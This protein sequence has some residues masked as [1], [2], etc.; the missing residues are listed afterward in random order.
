MQT[1]SGLVMCL[2]L[3]VHIPFSGNGKIPGEFDE[4]SILNKMILLLLFINCAC[5]FSMLPVCLRQIHMEALKFSQAYRCKWIT[6]NGQ[7]NY[8]ALL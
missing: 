7:P 8:A 5:L 1:F 2:L 3:N 6:V 4:L